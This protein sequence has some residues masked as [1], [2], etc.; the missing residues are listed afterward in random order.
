MPSAPIGDGD[1]LEVGLERPLDLARNAVAEVD[2]RWHRSASSLEWTSS[3][4]TGTVVSRTGSTRAG[5][6]TGSRS[7]SLRDSV[8]RRATGRSSRRA[9]C[10]SSRPPTSTGCRSAPTRAATPGFVRVVDEHTLAFPSY[11]GNGT[12]L[13]LGN[14]LVNPQVGILFLDFQRPKRLRVNG[15][16][17]LD[18]DDPLLATTRRRSSS[19]ASAQRHPPELPA[20]RA[21]AWSSSS[22]RGSSRTDEETP[23]PDWKRREWSHDALAAGDPAAAEPLLPD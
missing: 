6:P 22:A 19:C 11:D 21:P 16:A 13:S 8:H 12:Y 2:A 23:I 15:V 10:S 17:S 5:S 18:E 14:L 20:L 4:T 3:T 9:T 1:E 7:G